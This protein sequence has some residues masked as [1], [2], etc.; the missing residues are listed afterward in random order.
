MSF[1]QDY[2]DKLA[3]E[4][5]NTRELSQYQTFD[6]KRLSRHWGRKSVVST[7]A[8]PCHLRNWRKFAR[9]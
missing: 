3:I 9:P 8:S 4:G 2:N 6:L 7:S 1:Y 5:W